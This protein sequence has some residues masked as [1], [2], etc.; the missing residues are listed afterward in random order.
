MTP[1][2]PSTAGPT[3]AV[4][5]L[6]A[7]WLAESAAQAGWP[8]IALDLFG[9]LD[10]R[11]LARQ[12][13]PIGRPGRLAIDPGLLRQGLAAARDAGACAWIGG[14]GIEASAELLDAGGSALQ[15]WGMDTSAVAAVRTPRAFFDTLDRL[16][17][18]HPEVAWAP[19]LRREGWLY[20]RASGSGGWSVRPAD[21]VATVHP[22]GYFQRH[23]PGPSMSALCLADG[24]RARLVALN[25]QTVRPLG[26]S[27]PH[28]LAGVAG[29]VDAPVLQQRVE[30]AL[31][32]LVQPAPL[33][34][35]ATAR[36]GLAPGAAGGTPRGTRGAS[37]GRDTAAQRA[38]AR[39]GN[40][41]RLTPLQ[42]AAVGGQCLGRPPAAARPAGTRQPLCARRAGVQRQRP[43]R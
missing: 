30:Q 27:L 21:G 13:H 35:H 39:G 7:R 11:R 9:D 25:R 31:E 22:D 12:W 3:V 4:A 15:R 17:L 24:Q 18:A 26:A 34:E 19:P 6:T 20:K 40:P 42:P 37:A 36:R 38:V 23:Q 41:V 1:R 14:G 32:R 2:A 43:G 33:G 8:V 28:V 29:P 16:D 5:G 10:T